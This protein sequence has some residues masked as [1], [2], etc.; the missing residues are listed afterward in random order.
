[1]MIWLLLQLLCCVVLCGVGSGYGIRYSD[2]MAL[3]ICI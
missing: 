1:M 3:L 2:N